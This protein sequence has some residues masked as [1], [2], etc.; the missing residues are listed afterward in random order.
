V[1]RQEFEL[2]VRDTVARTARGEPVE[3]AT[4]ELKSEW[5]PAVQ[6]ARRLAGHANAARGE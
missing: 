1:R 4:T 2:W 5:I 6:A 3:D